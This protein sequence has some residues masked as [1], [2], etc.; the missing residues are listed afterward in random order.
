M[1]IKRIRKAISKL[2]VIEST[3]TK[4][5]CPTCLQL[6]AAVGKRDPLVHSSVIASMI[7]RKRPEDGR[8]FD[9]WQRQGIFRE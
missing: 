8:S 1:N 7:I 2:V 6:D 5:R 9:R 4:S 3:F